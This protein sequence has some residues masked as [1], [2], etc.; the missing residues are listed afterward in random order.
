MATGEGYEEFEGVRF[1]SDAWIKSLMLAGQFAHVL[2]F[3]WTWT[4]PLRTASG[5]FQCPLDAVRSMAGFTKLTPKRFREVVA[6]TTEQ[7]AAGIAFFP[8]LDYWWVKNYIRHR[9]GSP[10]K[11]T[12]SA[13]DLLRHP[14]ALSSLAIAYNKERDLDLM[15]L[16][17]L[18]HMAT[19]Q[20][21][22]PYPSD[23]LRERFAMDVS[24][25]T[26]G[27]DAPYPYPKPKAVTAITG[28]AKAPPGWNECKQTYHDGF[29]KA[30]GEKPAM[31]VVDFARL[32]GTLRQHYAGDGEWQKLQA[33]IAF[34][35]S[36]RDPN[37]PDALP[38]L[39]TILSK[40]HRNRITSLLARNKRG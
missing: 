5:L 15:T 26:L 16:E 27:L 39:Q 2:L 37:W 40:Y 10:N 14:A 20:P 28:S 1:W 3:Q 18:A 24:T 13:K 35:I 4:G 7:P 11:L 32:K 29:L 30:T 38:S 17:P 25:F 6:E 19:A 22:F 34:A 31:D 21:D 12:A 23:T 33:V 8:E 9:D 36:G